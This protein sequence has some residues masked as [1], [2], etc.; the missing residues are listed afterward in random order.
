[1]KPK[2]KVYIDGANMFY[3]QKK[4]GWSIDWKKVKDCLNEK[5]DVIEIR[6]YVGVKPRDERMPKFLR[7]LDN[8]G[9]KPITK[10][11][12]VIKITQ[13]D[14]K[15]KI[16][17]YPQIYKCNFDV[18][19]TADI[20]LDRTKLDQIIL[21]SGD[22]DFTY[23]AK[24]LRDLG[25]EVVVFSTRKMIAWELKLMARKYIFLDDLKDKIER[26]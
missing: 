23:L 21:F 8:I 11:V 22:S 5:W 6:Y 15:F 13:G 14:E 2:A 24:I 3:T 16:Y 7:Y 12:K 25:K 9:F 10:P 18:E 17:P 26:K 20:L 19:M 4:L 1:M